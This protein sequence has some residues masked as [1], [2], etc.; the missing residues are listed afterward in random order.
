VRLAAR[1][2]SVRRQIPTSPDL[3]I[4]P[5]GAS[6]LLAISTWTRDVRFPVLID[7]GSIQA[8]ED[9][10]RFARGFKPREILRWSRA[11][12]PGENAMPESTTMREQII[13]LAAL[14]AWGGEA[15]IDDDM[16]ERLIERLKSYGVEPPGLVFAD[17][18]DPSWTAA[19][20]LAAGRGQPIA[21]Y[22]RPAHWDSMGITPGASINTEVADGFN[23]KI[24]DACRLL[25]VSWD[26]L[27]DTLDAITIC[28]SIPAKV[29]IDGGTWLATTDYFGRQAPRDN[30]ASRWA[31]CGQIWAMGRDDPSREARAAYIA[32]SSLFTQPKSAWLVDGYALGQ[33]WAAYD[34]TDAATLLRQRGIDYT[35]DDYPHGSLERW[36]RR[37]TSPLEA[38][39]VMVNSRGNN[40]FFALELGIGRPADTPFLNVPAIVSIVHSFSAQYPTQRETIAGR[41]LERGA[42]AYFGSVDEPFLQAFIPSKVA[43]GRLLAP[44]PFAA[45]LRA[46]TG[47]AW[48]LMVFGDPLFTLGPPAPRA[49]VAL[50]LPATETLQAFLESALKDDRV[51]DAVRALVMMGRDQEAAELLFTIVRERKDVFTPSLAGAGMGPI[52]RAKTPGGEAS[53]PD[54][55]GA[56]LAAMFDKM[57]P[58]IRADAAAQDLLWL[59]VTPLLAGKPDERLIRVLRDF[60]RGDNPALDSIALSKAVLRV[61]GRA[62]AIAILKDALGR[63]RHEHDTRDVQEAL[64][65]FGER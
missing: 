55:R 41:W 36:R 52:F 43:A 30:N 64:K 42:F 51:E 34:M 53:S 17:A 24:Q 23:T 16:S 63:A 45:A 48:K 18:R 47:P 58:D 50:P 14:K 49:D 57:T 37:A 15:S 22:E 6:Y 11:S 62:S 5:D 29:Q 54:V 35:L 33:P 21:W 19:L 40:D 8:V 61:Q 39:L 2:E 44:M 13:E 25:E 56:L 38:G 31:W 1:V 27:G 3:V 9:I 65:E 46:D 60:V 59:G 28:G 12:V 20:A 4:V 26:G 7:D 32:M 10:A